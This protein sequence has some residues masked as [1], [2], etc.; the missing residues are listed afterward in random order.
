MKRFATA[1][2]LMLVVLMGPV[3]ATVH[4]QSMPTTSE[5]TEGGDSDDGEGPWR[6]KSYVNYGIFGAMHLV[7]YADINNYIGKGDVDKFGANQSEGYWKRMTAVGGARISTVSKRNDQFITDLMIM[8]TTQ[9]REGPGSGAT[10]ST[11]QFVPHGGLDLLKHSRHQFYPYLGLGLSY[12]NLTINGSNERF[13]PDFGGAKIGVPGDVGFG[14]E[15]HNPIWISAGKTFREA[16]NL[17]TFVQV[18]YQGE[19]LSSFW[20]IK[21]GRLERSVDHRYLGPYVRL[22][23]SFGQGDYIR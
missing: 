12:T 21:H 22:G 23:F 11:V 3:A 13:F 9:H 2:A 8:Y 4:A 18:G 20:M 19:L 1:T 7:D 5:T 17:S 15:L 14:F 16:F 6:L 10:L